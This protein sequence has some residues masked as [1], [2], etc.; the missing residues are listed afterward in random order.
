MASC[1]ARS[2]TASSCATGWTAVMPN[3]EV[4][5]ALSDRT[6]TS[7]GPTKSSGSNAAEEFGNLFTTDS[8][9]RRGDQPLEHSACGAESPVVMPGPS[10]WFH[11]RFPTRQALP[12]ISNCG[13][14]QR[15][16]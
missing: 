16:G 14:D 7:H 5:P 10:H 8:L 12:L 6:P 15:R 4:S 13:L 11:G 9:D 1:G 3:A 2:W